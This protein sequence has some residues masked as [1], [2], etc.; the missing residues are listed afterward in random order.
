MV[1]EIIA[2]V[3]L[4][5]APVQRVVRELS[6]QGNKWCLKEDLRR[7]SKYVVHS[8]VTRPHLQK[9]IRSNFMRY[10]DDILLYGDQLEGL[11]KKFTYY[12]RGLHQEKLPWLQT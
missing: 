5:P 10:W 4:T 8:V 2:V 12:C 9:S 11:D 1:L 3:K 7:A 6:E